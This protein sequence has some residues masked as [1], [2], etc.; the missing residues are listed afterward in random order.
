LPLLEYDFDIK[1][2]FLGYLVANSKILCNTFVFEMKNNLMQDLE[3]IQT[4]WLG[5]VL[6]L[7]C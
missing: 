3:I 1:N 5:L 7:L 6:T 2:D 4:T